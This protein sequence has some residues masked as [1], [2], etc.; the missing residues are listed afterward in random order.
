M[1]GTQKTTNSR[2]GVTKIGYVFQIS[3][4]LGVILLLYVISFCNFCLTIQQKILSWYSPNNPKQIARRARKN[5]PRDSRLPVRSHFSSHGRHWNLRSAGK[6][7]TNKWV[8][9]ISAAWILR[10][11]MHQKIVEFK[12]RQKHLRMLAK[13]SVS[14]SPI[15]IHQ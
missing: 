11:K 12:K 7:R 3:F 8:Q 6:I 14:V 15:K 2:K 10:M 13:V 4:F 5:H 1:Q 9:E